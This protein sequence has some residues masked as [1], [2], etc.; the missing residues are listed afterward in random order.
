MQESRE[1]IL[2]T[3]LQ[4]FLRNSF[5]EVT[6]KDLVAASD[7][8]KGAFYHYF[9]SKEQLF[10]EVINH[11]YSGLFQE[12]FSRYSHDSLAA[13]YRDSLTGL[14]E[15]VNRHPTQV[16][17][18]TSLRANHYLLVFDALKRLPS[19]R[20]LKQQQQEQELAGWSAIVRQAQQ[21][22]EIT[23]ALPEVQVAKLFIYLT[24]GVAVS[25]MLHTQTDE[26]LLE[27]AA[28]FDA[29]YQTLKV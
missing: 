13:F 1:H 21:T 4:L 10:E 2:T 20:L 14:T 25:F 9:D 3:S 19:F 6:I 16:S 29:L 27:V 23:A 18:D 7:L 26:M 8:S 11:F 15:R 22:G 5:R 17:G 24:H 12:D 28:G